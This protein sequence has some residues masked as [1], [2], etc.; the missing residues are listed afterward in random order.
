MT[1]TDHLRENAVLQGANSVALIDM[2]IRER[3]LA[4][5]GCLLGIAAVHRADSS[6]RVL[7][8]EDCELRLFTASSPGSLSRSHGRC[9]PER[10]TA[11]A[12]EM[13]TQ[14]RR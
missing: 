14:Y 1:G 6:F 8:N 10:L 3:V 5:L 9:G 11:S 13:V 12:V 4:S 7:S 2:C